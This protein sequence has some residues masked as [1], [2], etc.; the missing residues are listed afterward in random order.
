MQPF[1][2]VIRRFVPYNDTREE[3]LAKLREMGDTKTQI[4]DLN[5]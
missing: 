4:Y 2:E 3:F 1:S 5:E